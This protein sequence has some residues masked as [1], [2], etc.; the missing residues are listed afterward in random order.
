MPQDETR[1]IAKPKHR[2]YLQ[3]LIIVYFTGSIVVLAGLIAAFA[4]LTK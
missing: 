4:I 2:D 3:A 1:P